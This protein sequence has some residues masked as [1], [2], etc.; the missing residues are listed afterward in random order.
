MFEQVSYE[1]S[2]INFM[3]KSSCALF[4]SL[5]LASDI[6]EAS[7]RFI[8][9]VLSS[10][11]CEGTV[12]T[13]ERNSLGRLVK[14]EQTSHANPAIQ[15]FPPRSFYPS[16]TR[17]YGYRSILIENL[18]QCRPDNFWS[19]RLPINNSATFQ[20]CPVCF[21][22]LSDSKREKYRKW[23]TQKHKFGI[24]LRLLLLFTG[25]LLFL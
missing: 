5:T 21:I 7:N 3:I 8:T 19:F 13:V 16:Y 18:Q 25:S 14:R 9:A 23:E 4:L 10:P 22:I 1:L 20:C 17:V 6:S 2:T 15:T 11:S 24:R 12:E